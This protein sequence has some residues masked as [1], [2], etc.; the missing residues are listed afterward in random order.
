MIEEMFLWSAM[1]SAKTT[2]ATGMYAIAI[3]A[4]YEPSSSE[5]PPFLIAS[6]EV[7]LGTAKI[8]AGVMFAL[9]LL[10]MCGAVG[11][12]DFYG[13]MSARDIIQAI[14]GLVLVAA[15]MI[16]MKRIDEA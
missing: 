4:T 6:K 12:G 8:V 9:G 3:D 10:L 15:V 7:N 16:V 1:C 13:Y 14:I 5:K 2:K 11:N